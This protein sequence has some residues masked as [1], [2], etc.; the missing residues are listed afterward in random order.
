[1]FKSAV[2]STAQRPAGPTKSHSGSGRRKGGARLAAPVSHSALNEMIAARYESLRGQ[3][4]QIAKVAIERPTDIALQTVAAVAKVAKV[5]PSSVVR[6]AQAFGYPG[7]GE[8]QAIFRARLVEQS[9]SYGERIEALRAERAARHLAGPAANLV[10]FVDNGVAALYQLRDSISPKDL[11]RA[12]DLLGGA[13]VIYI[14]AQG[15]SFPVACYIAYALNRFGLPSQL[16]DGLGGMSANRLRL[17]GRGDALLA[18]SFK[19]YAHEVVALVAA[20]AKRGVPVV[21]ITDGALSP[22]AKSAKVRLDVEAGESQPFRS[23]VAPMC[24][25]QTLVVTLGDRRPVTQ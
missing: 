16:L 13:D 22:L 21:A 4:R 10:E 1:M 24:L 15:R 14:L 19:D 7:F 9:T 8:M 12:A 20:T 11:V 23:L 3:M 17:A 5:Q 2:S 18:I 25:A 6:F